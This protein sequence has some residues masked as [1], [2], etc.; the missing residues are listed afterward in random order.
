MHTKR[1]PRPL[2]A[3]LWLAAGSL[4]ATAAGCTNPVGRALREPPAPASGNYAVMQID[5]APSGAMISVNGRMIGA[6]PVTYRYELDTLGDVAIDLDI[7]ADFADSFGRNRNALPSSPVS[8]RIE[9]GDRAPE[10]VMFDTESA[11]V[12]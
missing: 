11:S 4:L 7:T 2:S 10:S 5:S 9:R 1:H 3:L 6:A 12:R 8:Q